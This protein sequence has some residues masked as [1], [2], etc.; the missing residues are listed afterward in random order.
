MKVIVYVDGACDDAYNGNGTQDGSWC[1]I[2][3]VGDKEK[4]ISGIAK[5]TTRQRM[6]VSG[7]LT[8]FPYLLSNG[9]GEIEVISELRY[10]VLGI[11]NRQKWIKKK[12]IAN[13]DLWYPLYDLI[14]NH[15]QKVCATCPIGK[16]NR[17][18]GERCHSIAQKIL[19]KEFDN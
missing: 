14:R 13:A 4:I 16:N 9:I 12:S 19:T 3:K 1:C 18:T 15:P 5:K 10:V 8:C 7:L 6:G 11:N 17:L 2:I